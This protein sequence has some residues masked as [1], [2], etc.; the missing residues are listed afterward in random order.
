MAGPA[1]TVLKLDPPEFP[2]LVANEH[3][4]LDAARASGLNVVDADLVRDRVGS[5]GLLV[6]RFDRPVDPLRPLL[7]FEDGCQVLDLPPASK[8]SLTSETVIG[9]LARA[10]RSPLVLARA[11]FQQLVFGY[12]T[13]NGDLHARNVGIL[14]G[15]SGEW[16]AAPA[17]DLPS[18]HPYGDTTV[19]LSVNGK[20]RED[21]GRADVLASA[22]AVGLPLRAAERVIDDIVG[23]SDGWIDALDGLPFAA[24]ATHRLSRAIQV[25]AAT[26]DGRVSGAA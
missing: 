26:A 6:R 23:R 15:A 18:S 16:T 25:S 22:A 17:F 11:Y 5:A 4:F 1:A 14:L 9:A 24:D 12:L 10:G 21:I 20:R 3:F 8:Y 2:H 7:A 13:C 19:A